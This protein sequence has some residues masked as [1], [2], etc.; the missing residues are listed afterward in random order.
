M[1]GTERSASLRKSSYSFD[2]LLKEFYQDGGAFPSLCFQQYPPGLGASTDLAQSRRKLNGIRPCSN[3]FPPNSREEAITSLSRGGITGREVGLS[4]SSSYFLSSVKAAASFSLS[5]TQENINSDVGHSAYSNASNAGALV[6]IASGDSSS[7]SAFPTRQQ[8]EQE[9]VRQTHA[10]LQEAKDSAAQEEKRRRELLVTSGIVGKVKKAETP[11]S[12]LSSS[13][14]SRSALTIV[15]PNSSGNAE[16]ELDGPI[17]RSPN[18]QRKSAVWAKALGEVSH[19]TKKKSKYPNSSSSDEEEEEVK[20]GGKEVKKTQVEEAIEAIPFCVSGWLNKKK[21]I[22]PIEQR[23]AQEVDERLN[24]QTAIG[25]HIIDLATAMRDGKK[26][27]QE[28]IEEQQRAQRAAAER[29][30]A[31]LEAEE[32]EK[33]RKLLEEKALRLSQQQQRKET[34]AE[35]LERIRVERELR[36]RE[37]QEYQRKRLRERAAARLHMTVEA[38]EADE[39]LLRSVDKCPH[40]QQSTASVVGAAEGGLTV[41]G[42]LYSTENARS[43]LLGESGG[44]KGSSFRKDG[45][46]AAQG[47]KGEDQEDMDLEEGGPQRRRVVH[48]KTSVFTGANISNEGVIRQM[49]ALEKAG[50]QGDDSGIGE[51]G[52]QGSDGIRWKDPSLPH[53]GTKASQDEEDEEDEDDEEENE[54]F[55]KL[56]KKRRLRL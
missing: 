31:Q 34:R 39:E 28:E 6:A 16:V 35:R 24:F 23:I 40:G 8:Q 1:R 44:E 46:W 13:S 54:K 55:R 22:V 38:L 37:Q 18:K 56:R 5:T 27:V 52:R 50:L 45:L 43:I 33:G 53:S 14:S 12:P 49:E 26:A 19:T 32:A 3:S 47:N 25:D 10:A 15:V 11:S 51:V 42:G 4:N 21:L 41:G 48:M 2:A 29:Q 9:T 7:F 17:V 30:Q 20:E 36:E